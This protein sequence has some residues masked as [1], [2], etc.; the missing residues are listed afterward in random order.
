MLIQL[1]SVQMMHTAPYREVQIATIV[2]GTSVPFC[3]CARM[4]RPVL[5]YRRMIGFSIWMLYFTMH[6][7]QLSHCHLRLSTPHVQNAVLTFVH[8]LLLVNDVFYLPPPFFS[9]P[10]YAAMVIV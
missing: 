5:M 10:L 2:A 7:I 3:T 1:I 8:A 9:F 4:A 6:I